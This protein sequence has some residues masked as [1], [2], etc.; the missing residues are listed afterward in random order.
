[1]RCVTL[2]VAT[3]IRSAVPGSAIP[4]LLMRTGSAAGSQHCVALRVPALG[5]GPPNTVT[6][7]VAPSAEITDAIG[8]TPSGT[9]RNNVPLSASS[10][11]SLSS[12]GSGSTATR[13]PSALL[14]DAIAGAPAMNVPSAPDS[15]AIGAV[16]SSLNETSC[17]T[18]FARESGGPPGVRLAA[19]SAGSL[20]TEETVAR[21]VTGSMTMPCTPGRPLKLA[22]DTSRLSRHARR[23]APFG[24]TAHT[25]PASTPKRTPAT[26]P[27]NTLCTPAG[28][29]R[30][31][32]AKTPG[33]LTTRCGC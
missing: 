4:R 2:P 26:R 12:A 21:L 27:L 7:A 30:C 15:I 8:N 18:D 1:M 24:T 17:V 9:D 6:H 23:N 5:F 16:G 32:T 33:S 13:C 3:S 20:L 10:T 28:V 14:V 31:P 11:T 19:T 22:C 25:S 29:T